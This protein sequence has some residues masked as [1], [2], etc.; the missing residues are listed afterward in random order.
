MMKEGFP[1]GKSK[2]QIGH[3]SENP[4]DFGYAKKLSDSHNIPIRI[5]TLT[6]PYSLDRKT[7]D[8]HSLL[9]C[10]GESIDPSEQTANDDNC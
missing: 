2:I 7:C 1:K 8:Q 4:S 3:V 10:V 9:K 6:H 5:R